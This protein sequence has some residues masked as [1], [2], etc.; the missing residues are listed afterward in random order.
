LAVLADARG[1]E[2][3][4]LIQC[5][6]DRLFVRLDNARVMAHQGGDGHRLGRRE[7]E[8][9]EHAPIGVLTRLAIRANLQS[10]GFL[11]QRQLLPGLWMKVLTETNEVVL[12]C[13]TRQPQFLGSLTVPLT[14]DLLAFG[15]VVADAQVF[16]EVFLGVTQSVLCL[17]SKHGHLT[18]RDGR[19]LPFRRPR[20]VG[21]LFHVFTGHRSF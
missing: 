18:T 11:A 20:L 3:L 14:Q 2:G 12:A 5:R 19:R 15:V 8:I 17:G 6:R 10:R 16:R 1:G 7:R 21:S 13:D 4:Q 9:V